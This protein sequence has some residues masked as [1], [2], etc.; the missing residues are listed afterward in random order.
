[1]VC[2]YCSGKT[3]VN[4]SRSS[5][6]TLSTWRRRECRSC[7]AIFTTREEPE[8]ESVI[9]VKNT[10]GALA[11][12]MRD[13]LFISLLSSVSHRKTALADAQSLTSTVIN[14]LIDVAK[15]GV[16]EV[17]AITETSLLVIK[18]FDPAAATYYRA[19]HS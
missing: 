2:I 15:H 19:H 5:T 6:K 17:H 1:M 11:P 3:G 13:K 10:S 8:L 12:F 7:H 9:R 14:Q 4:N 16:I 18:R